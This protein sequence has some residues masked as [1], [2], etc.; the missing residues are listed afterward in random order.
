[1]MRSAL[2]KDR[3]HCSAR[4]HA[5]KI[6]KYCFIEK[7][8]TSKYTTGVIIVDALLYMCKDILAQIYLLVSACLYTARHDISATN[9]H[10]KLFK[11]H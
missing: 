7:V 5:F 2:A 6:G 9:L 11:V 8:Y 1:M 10:L 4:L 3:A